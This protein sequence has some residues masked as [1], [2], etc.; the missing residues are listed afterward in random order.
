MNKNCICLICFKPN[1]IWF[2]FLSKFTVYD[3]YIIIDDNS[4]DY[5]KQYSKFSNINIIQINDEECKKNGFVNMN[6]T[7][8]K[9]IT[10]WE[11]SIYYFS[12]IN[13]RYNKLWFFEDDVFFYNE[14]TLVNID[15]NY[16]NFDLLSREF[17]NTYISGPKN[18]WHWEKINIHF[19][20]P[21]YRGMMCCIR[22][23]SQLLC[24]IRNYAK[25]H[26]TLFFLEAL[27][28]TICKKC[29]LEYHTP[30]QFTNIVYRKNYIDKDIDANNLFHPVKDITKHRYYRDMLNTITMEHLN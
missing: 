28:P 9:K 3:I 16:D 18:F 11:K 20:P 24:E 5:K 23:S 22:I 7:I 10:S 12:T 29:N 30:K 1:D 13:T 15:S 8:K 4:K 21:Y 19:Q 25:E 26:K 2:D 27:F 6:F 17:N 14:Q